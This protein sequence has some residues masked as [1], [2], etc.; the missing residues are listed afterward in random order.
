MIQQ[1]H[2]QHRPYCRLSRRNRRRFQRHV[3]A[4]ERNSSDRLQHHAFCRAPRHRRRT[5]RNKQTNASRVCKKQRASRHHNPCNPRRYQAQAF[6]DSRR[7]VPANSPREQPRMDWR[8]MY[9]RHR[10]ARLPRRHDHRPQCSLPSRSP[11]RH[12]PCGANAPRPHHRCRTLRTDRKASLIN[13]SLSPRAIRT[14]IL[15][16]FL[17]PITIDQRLLIKKHPVAIT[18]GYFKLSTN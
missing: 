8:R 14:T 16:L 5:S 11:P 2:A 1:V 15:A 13:P 7:S 17:I 6:R 3:K 12:I 10:K 18:T 4:F 9:R